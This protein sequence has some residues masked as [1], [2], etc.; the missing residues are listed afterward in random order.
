MA[1]NLLF[2]NPLLFLAWI[3]AVLVTIT[4]HEFSHA[5]VATLLGDRT[6]E[7]EGRLTFDPRAH[8]DMTGL[9]MLVLVGFGWGRPV[10]FNPHNLRYPRW[11]S[12]FVALAGPLANFLGALFFGG[13]VVVLFRFQLL[14][15]SNLLVDF[16]FS[17]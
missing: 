7:G 15:P 3:I 2:T 6:P 4:I 8:V 12:T 16:L 5:L 1:L 17:S 11:G 10:H 13:A 14:V 9:L